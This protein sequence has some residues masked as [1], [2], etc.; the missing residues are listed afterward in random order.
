[1]QRL[2]RPVVVGDTGFDCS[3]IEPVHLTHAH[4][5]RSAKLPEPP[6]RMPKL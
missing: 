3:D 4:H 5:E 2:V 1:L 6:A